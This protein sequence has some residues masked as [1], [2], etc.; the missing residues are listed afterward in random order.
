METR[1]I[2]K[3]DTNKNIVLKDLTNTFA[4]IFQGFISVF[5]CTWSVFGRPEREGTNEVRTG[6][7]TESPREIGKGRES[8]KADS[9]LK[10]TLD[11]HTFIGI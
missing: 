7:P 8:E 2:L 4:Q 1:R 5:K 11:E 10:L 3:L 6:S 9:L